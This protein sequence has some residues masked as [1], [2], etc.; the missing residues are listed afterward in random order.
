MRVI[1]LATPT[2][3]FDTLISRSA[4]ALAFDP[5]GRF[6]AVTAIDGS[7][8]VVDVA[9]RSIARSFDHVKLPDNDDPVSSSVEFPLAW[10]PSGAAL[11]LGTSQGVHIIARETWAQVYA[12]Q[13]R[14]PG[15]RGLR[16]P[17]PTHVA[18]APPATEPVGAPGALRGQVRR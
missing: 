8:A 15:W 7:A 9:A 14:H 3:A 1:D 17:L 18:T 11:A 2:S 13:V 5:S 6:L 12:L 10:H 16:R 4:K